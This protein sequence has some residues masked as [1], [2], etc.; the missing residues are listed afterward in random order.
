MFR[1]QTLNQI[2]LTGLERF[3]RDRY[4]VAS[5]LGQPHAILLRSH[6]LDTSSVPTSLTAIARADAAVNTITVSESTHLGIPVFNT[7]G[8]SLGWRVVFTDGVR[9]VYRPGRG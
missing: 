8:A 4:E 6:K 9:V 1:I 3:P 2:A 5:E 7:P